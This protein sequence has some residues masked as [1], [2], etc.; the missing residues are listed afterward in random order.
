MPV[1]VEINSKQIFEDHEDSEKNK[2]LGEITYHNKGAILEFTEKY[3]DQELKFKMTILENKVITSRN[4]QPMIF[5]LQNKNNTTL[6]TQYGV[7]NM[8]ITTKVVDITKEE[9]LIKKIHLEYEIEL[10]NSMKYDNVVE[11]NLS[12]K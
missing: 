3:E 9:D 12:E 4:N 11:I 8:V 7:L 1:E 5:D 6:N 10:E 2:C